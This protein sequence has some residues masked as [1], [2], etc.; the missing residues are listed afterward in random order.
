MITAVVARKGGVGKT[1]TSLGLT[2]A[3]SAAGKSVLVVDFDPQ[4]NCAL[5]MGHEPSDV[6]VLPTPPLRA[7]TAVIISPLP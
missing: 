5:G 1:S 4:G 7:T 3:L 2:D 6:L